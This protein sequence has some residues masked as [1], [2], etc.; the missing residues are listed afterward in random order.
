MEL[1]SKNITNFFFIFFEKPLPVA[2]SY[3]INKSQYVSNYLKLI[4]IIFKFKTLLNSKV[5]L[6]FNT[7]KIFEKLSI[8]TKI[9]KLENEY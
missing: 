5:K 7:I 9:A 3:W 2:Y 6:E 1:K 4:F 8:K